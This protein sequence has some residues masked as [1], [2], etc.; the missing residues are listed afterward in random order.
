[1]GGLVVSGIGV[2]LCLIGVIMTF[3]GMPGLM[4][5]GVGVCCAL[6]SFLIK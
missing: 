2:V 1:M 6:A 4:F 5:T 3:A